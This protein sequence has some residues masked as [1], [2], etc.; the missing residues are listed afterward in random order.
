MLNETIG[1]FLC[2]MNL[3]ALP[4][5]KVLPGTVLY[6]GGGVSNHPRNSYVL[7]KLSWIINSMENT[8]VTIWSEYGFHSFANWLEPLTRGLPPPDRGS[9]CPLSSTEYVEPHKKISWRNPPSPKKFLGT[10]LLV[11]HEDKDI[12]YQVWVS[13]EQGSATFQYCCAEVM[14]QSHSACQPRPTIFHTQQP[15]KHSNLILY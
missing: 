1:F 2:I 5:F 8:S 10:P 13:K 6:R 3:V 4:K 12:L 7:T 14:L 11:R 15:L 9:L